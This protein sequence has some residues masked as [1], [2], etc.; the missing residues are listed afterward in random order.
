MKHK[1]NTPE[2][3][4]SCRD[5]GIGLEPP[6]RRAAAHCVQI[7]TNAAGAEMELYSIPRDPVRNMARKPN[8]PPVGLCSTFA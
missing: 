2:V 4:I 6:S 1:E 5:Q 7:I 3:F 8:F